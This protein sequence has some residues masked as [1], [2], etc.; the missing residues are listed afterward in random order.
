MTAIPKGQRPGV[1]TSWSWPIPPR[2]NRY[3][4]TVTEIMDTAS[5]GRR[6]AVVDG[7][8][9]PPVGSDVSVVEDET[10]V[11]RGTVSKVELVLGSDRPARVVVW[12]A[13]E[14]E[15]A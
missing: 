2:A 8:I 15:P 6:V 1:A 10:H 4:V 11:R 7:A 3:A 9:W 13:L 14:R 12:A 5:D